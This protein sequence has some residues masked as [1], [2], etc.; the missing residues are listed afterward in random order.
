MIMCVCVMLNAFM[1]TEKMKNENNPIEFAHPHHPYL[2]YVC[3]AD[4]FAYF[5]LLMYS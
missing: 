4:R 5:N 2:P 3:T 1:L